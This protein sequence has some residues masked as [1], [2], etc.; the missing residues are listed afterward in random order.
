[1]Y[2]VTAYT[3]CTHFTF[4]LG[5]KFKAISRQKEEYFNEAAS[6]VTDKVRRSCEPLKLLREGKPSRCPQE[7]PLRGTSFLYLGKLAGPKLFVNFV[8]FTL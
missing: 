5:I 3:G 6:L 7:G 1:M 2:A 4:M 8:R